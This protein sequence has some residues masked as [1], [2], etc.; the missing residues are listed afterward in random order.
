MAKIRVYELAKNLNM[1]NKALLTKIEKMNISVGSHMSSLDD[2][3]VELIKTN[4]FGKKETDVDVKRVRSTVIRRRKRAS[5][6][7]GEDL[8]SEDTESE[9]TEAAEAP[10]EAPA[11]RAAS[12]SRTKEPVE[13]KHAAPETD[14]D[15][16]PSPPKAEVKTVKHLAKPDF[17]PARIVKKPV[18]AQPELDEKAEEPAAAPPA[19]EIPSAEP[20]APE[21]V[22]ESAPEALEETSPADSDA[23]QEPVAAAEDTEENELDEDG[24]PTGR[25]KKKKKFTAARIIKLPDPVPVTPD[26]TEVS[27]P[28]IVVTPAAD[29]S[30]ADRLAKKGKKGRAFAEEDEG[31]EFSKK[32]SKRKTVVEGNALY[33]GG[34]GRKGR[35]GAKG[36]KVKIPDGQK[37]QITV[38]KAIKRR[39]KIDDTIVLADLAKRMGIKASEMIAKLMGLGVMATV[40]QT[41]DYD[42]AV[43]VASEFGFEVERASFEEDVLLKPESED[44]P[45]ELLPRPPVVTIMGH[46]DH[47]KTSLLDVI[48]K[49]AIADGEAGGI[50]Q[51]IGAYNVETARGQIVFLDTPGHEAFTAMRARGA[52]VTD[53]VVLVVAADDGVMPQTIEAL[54]HAKAAKVPII[55]A[56]NK[57]DKD[58]ADIDRVKRE[59]SDHG[60]IPEDWGGDTIFVNVSAKKKIGITDLLEM[61]LL[62]AEVLEL[63]ANPNKFATGH[64][65]ES[66]LDSG[67]GPLATV[68]IQEGTL[69]TGQ[70]IVCGMHYGKIRAMFNDQGRQVTE[71]GPSIPVEVIGLTGVPEAGDELIALAADKDA[72]QVSVHRTQKARSRELA[73]NSRL[74]L[75]GLFEQ[76]EEGIVKDLNLIIKADVHGSIEALKEALGKLTT[77]EVKI[78]VIHSAT[79]TVTESDIS[80][81]AVSNAI[82]LGFNVRPATKVQDMAKEEH[83]DMRFYDII[84][85]AIKD[86][87]DAMVGLMESTFK[88]VILGRAEV[89]D[90]F[91]IPKRG[92]IAG[93]YVTEGHIQRGQR[94]RLLRDGVIIYDGNISSLKR[95]KDDAKEVQHGYECGIG[96]ENYN[97]IKVGDTL[98]CYTLEEVKPSLD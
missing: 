91:V 23:D 97:D 19:A 46:V 37:T 78:N 96:I 52:K 90:T 72:K 39:I 71:A 64:V 38:P 32:K 81:A 51:H 95:F 14:E 69:K 60:V 75:E 84:Y 49:T 94:I 74:S 21:T 43:L 36:G 41:I 89:R 24:T 82:I 17:E 4:L 22:V 63:K 85:D 30:P 86:L 92:T 62:Q 8:L 48:R 65:V 70:S 73:K 53:L 54:N 20:P 80:L 87:R 50:T 31:D 79:G 98:D 61:I 68:L 13:E 7:E 10:S 28:D 67:R 26:T 9:E 76:M 66:K 55:V 45:E 5:D 2:D 59:L 6:E 12:P 3:I 42:T 44:N 16:E 56:V 15:T 57:I 40:N 29:A 35:K 58:G 25:K 27:A 1:T 33:A 77:Q 93:A 47:G 34:K 11:P 18:P 83:V 88:E